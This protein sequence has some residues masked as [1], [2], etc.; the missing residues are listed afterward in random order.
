M[1][2]K[3]SMILLMAGSVMFLGYSPSNTTTSTEISTIKKE[4]IQGLWSIVSYTDVNGE[5]KTW[6][7]SKYK[8]I[9]ANRFAWMDFSPEKKEF[10]GSGG[11]TFELDGNTYKEAL[12]YYYSDPR[13]VG[14]TIVFHCRLEGNRWYHRGS[15]RTPDGYIF[16]NEVWERVGVA[17]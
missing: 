16:I 2:T 6:M 15:W 1:N 4:D 13:L 10:Y 8:F 5:E 11:G 9:V 12:E 17:Q 14:D 7:R 3:I